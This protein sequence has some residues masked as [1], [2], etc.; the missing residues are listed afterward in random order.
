MS[1]KKRVLQPGEIV[2]VG[3]TVEV[4]V[5]AIDRLQKRI[6]LSLKANDQ[7]ILDEKT[8]EKYIAKEA[9]VDEH[10]GVELRTQ[11]TGMGIFAQAFEN[12]K[13]DS[14]KKR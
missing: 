6:S 4:K 14:G 5:L 12:S 7:E 9:A 13:K 8:R 11:G 10:R 3:Q 2:S 1:A